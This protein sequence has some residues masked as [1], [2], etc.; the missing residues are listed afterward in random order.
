VQPAT[1]ATSIS[2]NA[3]GPCDAASHRIDHMALPTKHN[4]QTTSVGW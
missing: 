4:Y 3:N 1:T 2:A